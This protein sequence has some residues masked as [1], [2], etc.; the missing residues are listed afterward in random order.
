MVFVFLEMIFHL[1]FYTISD[2]I[3]AKLKSIGQ[4]L[5]SN[6]NPNR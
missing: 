6:R 2:V 3:V 4:T 5:T 1:A